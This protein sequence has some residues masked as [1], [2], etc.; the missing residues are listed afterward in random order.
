MD[1]LLINA[2]PK[3]KGGTSRFFS[4]MLR[5]YIPGVRKTTAS[6][7]RRQDFQNTLQAILNAD[8]VCFSFPLYVDG[9]PAHMLEFLCFAEAVLKNCPKRI[10]VYAIA[11][12]GF[13]EGIQNRPALNMLQAWCKRAGLDWYGAAGIGAGTMLKVI[14]VVFS[15]LIPVYL[16]LILIPGLMSGSL[17]S[18]SFSPVI[19]QAAV[20]LFL[21]AGVIF[22]L[23]RLAFAIKHGRMKKNMYTRI[24]LPSFIFVPVS[25]AFMTLSS[26]FNGRLV[27]TLLKQDRSMPKDAAYK[28]QDFFRPENGR[29][30]K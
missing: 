16:A 29:I 1:L 11:N 17:T 2:S 21:N 20:W 6:L 22:C 24:M 4:G 23:C 28:K 9:L 3:N 27:F 15:I 13:V 7:C 26:L 25:D 12:S 14:S 30:C 19:I 5:L 18:A 8:C 10:R